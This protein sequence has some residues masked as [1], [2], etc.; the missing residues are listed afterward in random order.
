MRQQGG[1][2]QPYAQAHAP[3][4]AGAIFIM[5]LLL[6]G[7]CLDLVTPQLTRYLVDHVLPGS[8]EAAHALQNAPQL[9]ARHYQLL[10]YLVAI[11]ASVQILRMGVSVINGRAGTRIGTAITADMRSRLVQHLEQLG[12]A[13]YD[14]QQVGSLVSRVSY[15]TE[16]LHGFV[17]QLTGGF[18]FQIIM[19]LG[20]G[21]MMIS[22]NPKL[23]MFTLIPAPVVVAGSFFFW[24]Y[25]YP[26]Y[27]RYWDS[28]S[29]QAGMLAG[30][31]SG[32]RVVK[33]FNQEHREIQRFDNASEKLKAARRGVD[34]G[35]NIRTDRATQAAR[36]PRLARA[37]LGAPVAASA[38][39]GKPRLVNW[40]RSPASGS[41]PSEALQYHEP[42]SARYTPVNSGMGDPPINL[43]EGPRFSN[44]SHGRVR[45]VRPD[46]EIGPDL[47]LSSAPGGTRIPNLLI[48]SP[49]SGSSWAFG[50]GR[51][52][53][54][55]GLTEPAVRRRSPLSIGVA[56][57]TA[58]NP[59]GG[60]EHLD[61]HDVVIKLCIR[62]SPL[63][64]LIPRAVAPSSRS[65]HGC[66]CLPR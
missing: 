55:P 46:K 31:L 26:R 28:S 18:L 4:R 15:D 63:Q 33:A 59:V 38:A 10:L 35:V 16:A 21:I 54:L 13:Y 7:I 12:V 48:R 47:D 57:R 65:E 40:I 64:E 23:A 5:A 9:T 2:L 19:I 37:R 34:L 50:S 44:G 29:K 43:L 58:V 30:M 41:R 52:R 25:I 45:A 11:L 61:Q 27:Y 3:Y 32:I 51:T 66:L 22:I 60:L 17:N 36:R 56:V 1:R 49:D 6:V 42:F 14:R 24:R 39:V 53:L 20:V 62:V 8:P